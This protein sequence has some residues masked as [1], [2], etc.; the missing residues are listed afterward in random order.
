M[1]LY[2]KLHKSPSETL[3]ILKTVYS[4]STRRYKYFT[5][6]R[7]V[8]NDDERQGAPVMK[9]RDKNEVKSVNLCH[10]TALHDDS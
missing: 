5:E 2:V 7:V 3:H 1:K 9:Q 10:L 6:G 8:V 4:E